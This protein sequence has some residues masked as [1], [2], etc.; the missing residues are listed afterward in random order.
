M[1]KSPKRSFRLIKRFLQTD[2]FKKINRVPLDRIQKSRIVP[3][4]TKGEPFGLP[5]T[6]GNVKELVV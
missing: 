1:P 3:K 5:S 6:F 2:N 4:K